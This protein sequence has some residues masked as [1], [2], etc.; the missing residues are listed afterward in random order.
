VYIPVLVSSTVIFPA[1]IVPC[2]L[3]AETRST[4]PSVILIDALVVAPLFVTL[5]KF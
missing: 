2:S 5:C 3:P 4:E 1:D